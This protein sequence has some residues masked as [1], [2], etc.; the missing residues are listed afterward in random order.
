MER[1]EQ[2]SGRGVLAGPPPHCSSTTS[3]TLSVMFG[4]I[5][6][7]VGKNANTD[8][9]VEQRKV[10]PH[11]PQIYLTGSWSEISRYRVETLHRCWLNSRLLHSPGSQRG[12]RNPQFR[13]WRLALCL[14][15]RSV[16]TSRRGRPGV[17]KPRIARTSAPLWEVTQ[18]VS[19]AWMTWTW[20]WGNL[21]RYSY[22]HF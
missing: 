3:P 18:H 12:N 13:S 7:I 4:D 22:G 19:T 15:C 16:F 6:A 9:R 10:I 21:I 8:G 11:N 14:P 5:P 20:G 1:R 17:E 2:D